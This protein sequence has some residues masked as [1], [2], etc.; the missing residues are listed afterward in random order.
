MTLVDPNSA[1][2][3]PAAALTVPTLKTA[4][5]WGI[6]LIGTIDKISSWRRRETLEA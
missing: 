3:D 4:Q 1:Y 2:A 5:K 6:M